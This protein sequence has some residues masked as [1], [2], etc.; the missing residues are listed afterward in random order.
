MRRSP[1]LL[2]GNPHRLRFRASARELFPE[3]R[4]HEPAQDANGKMSIKMAP[5]GVDTDYMCGVTRVVFLA[6]QP[7]GAATLRA[8]LPEQ[9]IEY[10]L[11]DLPIYDSRV[12]EEQRA[13]LQRIAGLNPVELRYSQLDDAMR[14]L[15]SLLI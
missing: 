6:R 13:S 2:I 11:S 5:M 1:A 14:Q 15:E 9:A 3:L 12:R 8:I 7:D 4:A 10:F